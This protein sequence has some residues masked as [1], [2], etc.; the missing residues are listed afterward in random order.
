MASADPFHESRLLSTPIRD[1]GLMIAGTPLEP[2][3]GE[4]QQELERVGI[5]RLKPHFYL[6]DEWGVPFQTISIGIPFYLARQDL[7]AVHAER[8]G[9]LEGAGRLDLL[10]YL[11]H[12]MGHVVNY[13]YKLY[14]QE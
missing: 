2:W 13:G 7:T 3:L 10:R 9:H 12:E 8:I 14:E 4:F 5:R 11:R 1:L 6:T